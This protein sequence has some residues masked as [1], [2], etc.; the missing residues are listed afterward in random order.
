MLDS[1]VLRADNIDK[2]ESMVDAFLKDKKNGVKSIQGMSSH[3]NMNMHVV[4]II[5]ER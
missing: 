2:L 5:Y 3:E 1:R 4:I